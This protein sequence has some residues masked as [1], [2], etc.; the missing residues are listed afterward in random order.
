M[1]RR[2]SVTLA[3]LTLAATLTSGCNTFSSNSNAAVVNGYA[4]PVKQY[5]AILAGVAQTPETFQIPAVDATG[6]PGTTARSI[7]GQWVSNA[8]MTSALASKGVTVSAADRKVAEDAIL[9][10]KAAAVWA[11]LSPGLKS[12]VLDSQTLQPA[13]TKAFGTDAQAAL[14]KAAR[15][16]KITIDSRYGMWDAV[17]GQVAATR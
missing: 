9:A 6:M 12:F 11:T 4:L 5:E 16:S 2:L 15:A 10:G 13:F 14:E 7:L 3:A 1:I 17:T 8:V